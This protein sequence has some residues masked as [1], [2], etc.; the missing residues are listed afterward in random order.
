MANNYASNPIILDTFSADA[1]IA[2]LAFGTLAQ[3]G[4]SGLKSRSPLF[5]RSIVFDSG[6][7]GDV[8][9]LED[10]NGDQVA[11]LRCSVTNEAVVHP[12]F[13][14]SGLQL[15][16]SDCLVTTGEVRIYV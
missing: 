16:A 13:S 11:K 5:I 1:D 4:G 2:N 15:D 6:T 7:S 12:G 3:S 14:C 10:G 9:V 8:V